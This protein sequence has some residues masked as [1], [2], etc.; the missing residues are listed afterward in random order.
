MQ[1]SAEGLI[2]VPVSDM[3][4]CAEQGGPSGVGAQGP[5]PEHR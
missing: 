2:V 1:P 5:S 4:R 3:G